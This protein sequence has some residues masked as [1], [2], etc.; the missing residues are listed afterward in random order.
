MSNSDPNIVGDMLS[1]KPSSITIVRLSS[2]AE[3]RLLV[4][5]ERCANWPLTFVQ[6]WF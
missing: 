5:K 4:C 6:D 2:C 3:Y 1:T